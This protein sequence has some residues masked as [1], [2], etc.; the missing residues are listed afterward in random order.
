MNFNPPDQF[1]RAL[2]KR[3]HNP[4]NKRWRLRIKKVFRQEAANEIPL[5]PLAFKRYSGLAESNY[6]HSK[7]SLAT[8]NNHPQSPYESDRRVAWH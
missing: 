3:R 1:C 7:C 2:E 4:I 8:L 6:S 5:T